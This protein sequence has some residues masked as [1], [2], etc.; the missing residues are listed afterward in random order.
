MKP[1]FALSNMFGLVTS[2]IFI[3]CNPSGHEHGGKETGPGV[4]LGGFSNSQVIYE[5]RLGKTMEFK[6]IDNQGDI[7]VL[8]DAHAEESAELKALQTRLNGASTYA[9]MFRILDGDHTSSVPK[10]IQDLDEKYDSAPIDQGTGESLEESSG[11]S[12]SIPFALAKSADHA[13]PAM[14]ANWNWGSDASWFKW[15]P[16]GSDVTGDCQSRWLATNVTWAWTNRYSYKHW[17]YAMAA[18]HTYGADFWYDRWNGSSWTRMQTWYIKPRHYTY[19]Y[20]NSAS[21]NDRKFSIY[22][23][24][25]GLARV[26]LQVAWDFYPLGANSF[27]QY[28]IGSVR[29]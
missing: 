22:G 6:L 5:K 10:N 25:D 1:I 12:N 18:S 23:R 17:A 20:Y 21:K 14:D 2:M 27:C 7:M 19:V 28:E 29:Q 3:G 15:L 13:N 8:L 16:P 4:I 11:Q 26:H 9:D 24:G